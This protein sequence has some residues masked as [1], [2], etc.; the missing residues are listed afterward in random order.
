MKDNDRRLDYESAKSDLS[1]GAKASV[2]DE[3]SSSGRGRTVT[4]DSRRRHGRKPSR[5]EGDNQAP[6][7]EREHT[8]IDPEMDLSVTETSSQTRPNRSPRAELEGPG[9]APPSRHSNTRSGL[10]GRRAPSDRRPKINLRPPS[11]PPKQ[12]TSCFSCRSTKEPEE[13]VRQR[14]RSYHERGA[15]EEQ[16]PE[17]VV[18]PG[19]RKGETLPRTMTPEDYR[20]R[21]ID[22]RAARRRK[23]SKS[24]SKSVRV[25]RRET[26]DRGGGRPSRAP[27]GGLK[28]Q[29]HLGPGGAPGQHRR[30]TRG[31]SSGSTE[32]GPRRGRSYQADLQRRRGGE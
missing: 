5:F 20:R 16:I 18:I 32:S 1:D 3:K 17:Q 30:A 10:Q 23:R 24:G 15:T 4:P 2:D 31:D 13:S 29:A 6:T 22:Y 19:P 25:S 27:Q 28:R 26:R 14:S 7:Q 21:E 8:P 12:Q 11:G 9:R